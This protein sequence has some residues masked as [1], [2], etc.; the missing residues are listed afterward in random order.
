MIIIN[1]LKNITDSFFFVFAYIFLGTLACSDNPSTNYY[2]VTGSG[3]TDVHI[4]KQFCS[5]EIIFQGGT[6]GYHSFRIPA[7]IK[8]SSGTL[9]AF[10]EGRKNNSHDYGDIDVVF[11]RSIDNGTTW[12]PLELL[13]SKHGGACGN[14]TPVVDFETGA[15]WIFMSYND[16]FHSQRG[17]NG[18][19][20]INEWGD[21]RVY[22]NV[23]YNNGVSWNDLQNRTSELVPPEYCWDAVG[24]GNGIQIQFGMHKGRLLIPAIGRNIYS[25]DHGITWDYLRTNPG[26]SEGTIVELCNGDLMR[27]DRG[28]CKMDEQDCTLVVNCEWKNRKRRQISTSGDGGVSWSPWESD[29]QLFDPNCQGSIIRYTA[30]YPPRLLFINP[31]S[32]KARW[33]MR[34]RI[35]YDEGKTWPIQRYLDPDLGGYSSLTKTADLMVA[36]LQEIGAD[37]LGRHSIIFRKFNLPWIL[38][39]IPEPIF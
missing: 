19:E 25:D 24:P 9:I 14:P 30:S 5:E 13:F 15:I 10:C 18:Y 33:K 20:Q 34:V 22:S 38:N 32:T 35:S 11:R 4:R 29:E 39:G 3:G 7:I 23:S 1:T 36:S 17:G 2:C 27:N 31:A 21:R 8:S 16:E 26:T 6:N 12:G 37:S 28:A